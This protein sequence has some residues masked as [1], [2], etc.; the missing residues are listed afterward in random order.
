MPCERDSDEPLTLPIG[1]T[2]TE[3]AQLGDLRVPRDADVLAD[4][5]RRQWRRAMEYRLR[6]LAGLT[7]SGV[8]IASAAE[9][10]ALATALAAAVLCEFADKDLFPSPRGV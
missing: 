5:L 10:Q 1:E 4:A 9:V 3:G 6:H 7:G 8:T 2:D